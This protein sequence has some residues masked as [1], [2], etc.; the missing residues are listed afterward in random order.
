MVEYLKTNLPSIQFTLAV[1][2]MLDDLLF[3]IS[4]DAC[5]GVDNEVG[6]ELAI[7]VY[8][9][10]RYASDRI[11]SNFHHRLLARI[12]LDAGNMDVVMQHLTQAQSIMPSGKLDEIMVRILAADGR[13]EDAR[14]Y[15][16]QATDDLPRHPFRRIAGKILLK[17]L[18]REVDEAELGAQSGT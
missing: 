2:S 15:I 16:D 18:R 6:K 12:A 11:Y 13:F 5:N 1:G 9:N 8:S 3:A 4:T 17:Q 7:A 10:P 14:R